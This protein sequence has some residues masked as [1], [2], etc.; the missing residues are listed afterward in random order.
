MDIKKILS[1]LRKV[2]FKDNESN[3]KVFNLLVLVLIGM[4]LIIASNFFKNT[5]NVNASKNL[6]PNDKNQ[7]TKI[8][9]SNYETDLQYE[10]KGKL[11]KIQGI[12]KVDVMIYF[13]SGEEQVPAVNMKESDSV[14]NEQ[15]TSGG[16]RKIEQNDN[17]RNVV[18]TNENG[19][20]KPLILKKYK[21]KITGVLVIAE[22]AENKVTELRISRAVCTLFNLPNYKVNVYPMK[23]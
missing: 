5:K 6:N 8:N 21:P 20:N 13:D 18:I 7:S 2:K 14:T 17:D 9:I 10:L 1:N 19:D 22:G 4:I 16:K 11:E 23:K 12:G 15:D 3:K